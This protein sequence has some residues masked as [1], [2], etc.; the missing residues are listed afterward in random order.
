M[1]RVGMRWRRATTAQLL[2]AWR[3]PQAAVRAALAAEHVPAAVGPCDLGWTHVRLLVDDD[4]VVEPR[5]RVVV[6]LLD[7]L[8][9]TLSASAVVCLLGAWGERELVVVVPGQPPVSARVP[10]LSSGEEPSRSDWSRVLAALGNLAA[11]EPV[12]TAAAPPALSARKDRT[13]AAMTDFRH[14]AVAHA[15]GLPAA[16]FEP[17][18]VAGEGIEREV[19]LGRRIDVPD[20]EML[21]GAL[22]VPLQ[23]A[24]V[25]DVT[26]VATD[27]IEGRQVTPI[28]AGMSSGRRAALL[29]W[30]QADARGYQVLRRGEVVDAHV[31]DRGWEVVELDSELDPE[32]RENLVAALLPGAGDAE[33][34]AKHIA[35][36]PAV[37][38]VSV[39]SLLRR[40][41]DETV[42]ARL[43]E[44]VGVDDR[45]AAVVEGEAEFG[46]LP[47]AQPVQAASGAAALWA[48]ARAP[49]EDEPRILRA[50]RRKPWWWRLAD[51][52]WVLACVLWI[53]DLWP[54]GGALARAGAVALALTAVWS[55][56]DA[57]TPAQES[58]RASA[59]QVGESRVR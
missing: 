22:R 6:D 20:V 4:A 44:L 37:D 9:R 55:L 7:D 10:G 30:R 40:D 29:L 2:V 13:S 51:L 38:L 50:S 12:L 36:D 26:V 17:G 5:G 25:G 54:D 16:L 49:R 23:A 52:L 59:R 21:A 43:C 57:V 34:L 8:A 41:P 33:I 42:L 11:L 31:W 14:R 48:A 53:A 1:T 45:V 15:A 18:S 27:P 28:A 32:L 3:A 24:R 46:Q 35:A 56:Y 47:G 58:A 19:A 39:R